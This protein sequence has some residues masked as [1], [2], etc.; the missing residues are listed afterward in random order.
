M[1]GKTAGSG[2]ALRA[3]ALCCRRP[4][5]F[6]QADDVRLQA[7]ETGDQERIATIEG[8]ADIPEVQCENLDAGHDFPAR[9]GRIDP[10]SVIGI[11]GYRA[12]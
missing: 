9:P 4:R 7:L 8:F 3:Y 11:S 1:V 2:E 5:D 12:D 10:D 6:L